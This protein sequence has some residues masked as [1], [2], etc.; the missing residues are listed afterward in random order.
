M[1]RGHVQQVYSRRETCVARP[2]TPVS[3]SGH[4]AGDLVTPEVRAWLQLTETGDRTIL[5]FVAGNSKAKPSSE[6][7][8]C[9]SFEQ[10]QP[11]RQCLSQGPRTAGGWAPP[12]APQVGVTASPF[13]P[14]TM[15]GSHTD[16]CFPSPIRTGADSLR[17]GFLSPNTR[18]QCKRVAQADRN[19]SM[20]HSQACNPQD[21][22]VALGK[23]PS[24]PK[25]NQVQVALD[26]ELGKPVALE[27]S[28]AL[29]PYMV[30]TNSSQ[31]V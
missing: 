7:S 22:P 10:D 26:H 11:A 31:V 30:K 16:P 8:A 4:V 20:R 21:H 2:L 15:C 25:R 18:A 17:P 1:V 12:G 27:V 13:L 5:W 28:Q 23:R 29:S 24:V 6:A 3:A 14:R 9:R 19:I